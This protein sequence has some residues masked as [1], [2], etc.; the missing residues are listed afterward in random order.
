[1]SESPLALVARIAEMIALQ[2]RDRV[3]PQIESDTLRAALEIIIET[4]SDGAR[5]RLHI[6][7]YW[8]VYYHDGR[9]GFSAP[10]GGFLVFYEDARDD[11]RLKGG[12][13]VTEAD[14]RH[15]TKGEFVEG[16]KCNRARKLAGEVPFMHVVKSVG[17]ADPHPFFTDGMVGFSE[18]VAPEVFREF[19]AYMRSVA[20][21]TSEKRSAKF[22]L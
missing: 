9:R 17:P 10:A 14:V 4:A 22:K 2:A 20:R 1:M 19:D 8:A 16:L 5:A 6:P 11:P 12:R 7:H 18:E 21:E 13:P 15:L 3:L